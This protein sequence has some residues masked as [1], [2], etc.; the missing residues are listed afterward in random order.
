LARLY[1]HQEI[2]I[3]AWKKMPTPKNL[4]DEKRYQNLNYQPW[5]LEIKN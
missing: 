3:L 4:L 5:S 2:N 1:I